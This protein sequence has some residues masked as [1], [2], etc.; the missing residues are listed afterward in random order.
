MTLDFSGN[1]CGAAGNL[2]CSNYN[3]IGS[4]DGDQPGALD[5]SYRSYALMFTG[6]VAVSVA[7]RRAHAEHGGS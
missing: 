7:A 2:V 5:V 1:I 3:E 4:N 6:L